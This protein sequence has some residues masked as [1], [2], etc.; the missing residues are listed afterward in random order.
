MPCGDRVALGY[1]MVGSPDENV[2]PHRRNI[3]K[4]DRDGI[5]LGAQPSAPVNSPQRVVG[6][7]E[8]VYSVFRVQEGVVPMTVGEH[9]LSIAGAR[10]LMP[11]EK[12][13]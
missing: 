10:H 1:A 12:L 2:H 4:A 9:H 13:Q 5:V 11:E 3:R 7:I 6:E 8:A